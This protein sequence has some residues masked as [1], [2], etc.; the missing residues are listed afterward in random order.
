MSDFAGAW[1]S[2]YHAP[3]LVREVADS[4]GTAST[5][6]DGTLGGGGHAAALLAAGARVDGVDRDPEAVAAALAR[7]ADAAHSGRFRAFVANFASLDLVPALEGLRYAG[8]LLDLGVSSHQLDERARGFSFRRGEPL[9]MRMTAFRVPPAGEGDAAVK[10]LTAATLL[11]TAS[12]AELAL[13]FREF[14]DEPRA[15][16]LARTVVHR[17]AR[18]L[19]STSDDLVD[20]IRAALG[21][22]TGPPD[23]ARLFQAVRMAVNDER[24]AL[25]TALPALRDRLLAQGRLAVISYHSGEDRIVKHAFRD[26]SIGCRCP[27]RQPVCTCGGPIGRLVTRRPIVAD[28][29]EVERNPRSR[30]AKLR[31]WERAA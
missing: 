19:L 14:G 16:R 7:L 5:V 10:A 6:L 28:T 8:V 15:V 18:Q 20:A 27:P 26:W 22:R 11:N 24:R 31:V 9:D 29:G 23:F 25:E 17:R 13:I 12:E 4:L 3:A 21:P 30:S 2:A 1:E